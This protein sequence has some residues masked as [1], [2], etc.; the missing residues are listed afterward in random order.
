MK[1]SID[2]DGYIKVS[3]QKNKKTFYF[4]AHRLVAIMFLG[5]LENYEVNHKDRNK[6][7]NHVNNLE[8]VTKSENQTHR[9][10]GE[11]LSSIYSGVTVVKNRNKKYR[12]QINLNGKIKTLSSFYNE[13]EAANFLIQY[14]KTI[15]L[16]NNKY[17]VFP[18]K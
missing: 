11:K 7:N 2:R 16:A 15:N 1:C 10:L 17:V 13:I 9:R 5:D 3:L 14:R 18:T 4:S 6:K 12:V 8:L